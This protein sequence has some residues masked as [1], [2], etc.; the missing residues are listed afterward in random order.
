[1]T[2]KFV[3]ITRSGSI[4]KIIIK[5]YDDPVIKISPVVHDESYV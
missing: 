5:N 1:M 2:G 3:N 4:D